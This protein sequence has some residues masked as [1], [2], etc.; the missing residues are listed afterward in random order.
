MPMSNE[1]CIKRLERF[2]EQAKDAEEYLL[3]RDADDEDIRDVEIEIE[4]FERCIRALREKG[5]A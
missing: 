4:V 1:E 5:D 3:Q 2:L